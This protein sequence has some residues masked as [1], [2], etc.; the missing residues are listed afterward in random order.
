MSW[1]SASVAPSGRHLAIR[2]SPTR[3]SACIWSAQLGRACGAR[4]RSSS[5]L[6][7]SGGR[8]AL[9]RDV[10]VADVEV[11]VGAQLRRAQAELLRRC[12]GAC[13]ARR[14]GW[15]RCQS[16]DRLLDRRPQLEVRGSRRCAARCPSDRRPARGGGRRRSGL[17]RC[18]PVRRCACST[19]TRRCSRHLA[20]R[21]GAGRVRPRGAGKMR[22]HDARPG[23]HR[24]GRVAVR[25]DEAHVGIRRHDRFQ[26]EV[27]VRRLEQPQVRRTS[28]LQELHDPPVVVVRRTSGRRARHQAW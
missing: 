20:A 17:R 26:V 12:S 6:S 7:S 24:L 5:C 16:S 1:V 28:R 13:R 23:R 19:P 4:S 2:L 11:V 9:D 14:T 21:A 18:G 3:S 22:R 15:P 27:V 8:S 10:E 25:H